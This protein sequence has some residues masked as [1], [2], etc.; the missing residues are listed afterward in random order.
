MTTL[1]I[2]DLHLDGTRPA[3]TAQFLENAH[4]YQQ[5]Y[6]QFPHFK[7]LIGRTLHDIGFDGSKAVAVLDIGSGFGARHA[8]GGPRL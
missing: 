2:S 5:G 1:F 6:L 7:R 8:G 4:L 3:I